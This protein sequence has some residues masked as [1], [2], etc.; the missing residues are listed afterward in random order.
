[1][2]TSCVSRTSLPERR[3][4]LRSSAAAT[5]RPFRITTRISRSSRIRSSP[6]WPASSAMTHTSKPMKARAKRQK[7]SSIIRAGNRRRPQPRRLLR[8]Q[9]PDPRRHCWVQRICCQ[10]KSVCV[11]KL[12]EEKCEPSKLA[13]FLPRPP[14][15]HDL[16]F[17]EEFHRVA[18]LA[19]QYPEKALFP[20]AE[21][22]VS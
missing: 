11:L 12:L 16:R 21:R 7:S 4:A 17:R 2:K 14:L 9:S 15:N 19:V 22:E 18:A 8:L 20:S 3:T 1:M 13:R 6:A 10:E 5:T